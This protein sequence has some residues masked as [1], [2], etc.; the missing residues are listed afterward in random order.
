MTRQEEC[1]TRWANGETFTQIA[2]DRNVSRERVQ[3]LTRTFARQLYQEQGDV[4]SEREECAVAAEKLAIL[5]HM[6]IANKRGF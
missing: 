6:S 4:A 3:Q 5:R 1:F 2:R